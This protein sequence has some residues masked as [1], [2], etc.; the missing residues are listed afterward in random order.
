[1]PLMGLFSDIQIRQLTAAYFVIIPSD[2][3]KYIGFSE[4]FTEMLHFR[5]NKNGRIH[6]FGRIRGIFIRKQRK[7]KS[8][9]PREFPLSYFY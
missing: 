5:R 9:S 6:R 7:R 8:L 2:Q 4:K 1:M 3:P